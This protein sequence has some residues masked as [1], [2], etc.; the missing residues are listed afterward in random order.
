LKTSK[1]ETAV[2]Y[3]EVKRP[4]IGC[5]TPESVCAGFVLF[6]CILFN[7]NSLHAQL[8]EIPSGDSFRVEFQPGESL[9]PENSP[10]LPDSSGSF[11]MDAGSVY[12]PVSEGRTTEGSPDLSAAVPTTVYAP[13]DNLSFS[14]PSIGGSGASAG[15]SSGDPEVRFFPEESPFQFNLTG[16]GDPGENVLPSPTGFLPEMDFQPEIS[17]EAGT[18]SDP[19][20]WSGVSRDQPGMIK[21]AQ[22]YQTAEME[23]QAIFVPDSPVSDQPVVITGTY[24]WKGMETEDGQVYILGGDCQVNQGIDVVGGPRAVVWVR[25]PVKE[26]G[27]PGQAIVYLE[28]EN[29]RSPLRIE[30]NSP[31]AE[32]RV[33]DTAWLGTFKTMA[34]IDIH[35][36]SP[37]DQ[38]LDPESLYYRAGQFRERSINREDVRQI[39]LTGSLTDSVTGQLAGLRDQLTDKNA[40]RQIRFFPRYD[41]SS[42]INVTTDPSNPDKKIGIINGGVNIILS[43]EI[44]KQTGEVTNEIVDISTD[45]AVIW[46]TGLEYLNNDRENV[47]NSNF[48]LEIFLEGN[49]VFRQADRVI[50]AK[51]M[52]YDAKNQ[53]GLIQN[54]EVVFPIPNTPGGYFRLQ[55]DQIAQRG[56]SSISATNTWVSTSMMGEPTYRLQSNSLRAESVEKPLY[57]SVTGQPLVNPE[58]GQPLSQVNQYLVAENNFVT[59]GCLPVFYWP[60]MAMD[61]KDQTLYLRDI[62]VGSDSIYGVQVKTRWNPYQLLN[63]GEKCR[64]K[65]T[66]WDL[67]IDYLSDR[68]LGHGTTFVYNRDTVFGFNTPAIGLVSYYGISDKGTDNLGLGRRN[69][70]FPH[71]YRYRLL[72]KHRQR[73]DNLGCFGSGWTLTGQV[74]TSRDRN[75]L[76]QYF[77]NE[78]YSASNPETSVE[79]KK[80]VNNWSLGLSAAVRTDSFYTQSNWLPRLDHYWM[81]QPIGFLNNKVVYYE[82]TKLGFAQ[83][84]TTDIPYSTEDKDLWRYLNWELDPASVSNSPYSSDVQPLSA[85]S[86]DFSTRHELDIPVQAG[87]FKIKPYGLGEFA[88]WGQGA[89]KKNVTRLY[90]RGGVRLDL[91]LWMVNS[92]VNSSTWYLNGLAHKTNF[93]VDGSYSA[94]NRSFDELILYEPLDDWQI[95]DFRRRY[96]VTTFG[97]TGV[98]GFSDSIPI[99]FDERY[100]ALR[101]G[102]LGGSVSSPGTEIAD[103]LTLVRFEWQNRWQTKRGPIGQRHTVDWIT[104]NTGFNLYPKKKE[105]FDEYLGLIDYD[106]RW[107]VG[108]RFSVLSSGMYDVFGSGQRITRMGVMTKKPGLSS[109]YF[110]VDRLAGPIDSTYL[111]LAINYRMSE[112]WASGFSTSYDLA[113]RKNV[114]QDLSVSRIGESF[115]VTL[116]AHI[117]TSKDN[118]GIKFSLEPIFYN[119]IREDGLL[120][121]GEM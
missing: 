104:F 60:W 90:G 19:G 113:E 32:A 52:Y 56:P 111:N 63:I 1:I 73:F 49:I 118:W 99:R 46:F 116:G 40:K 108:D 14:P 10:L 36:A 105:N 82:H 38:Q 70:T 59:V 21:V 71:S 12:A 44:K 24:G 121:L 119:R 43:Q 30:L 57:D 4:L 33:N 11:P 107:H 103:D 87:P 110:G 27:T 9:S 37:G 18:L 91:P 6:F 35:I 3:Q 31:Y 93:V 13:T 20:M 114:G 61:A 80:T 89:D 109:V 53:I 66:E 22:N 26:S 72:A 15:H 83:F 5:F 23:N 76:A 84:K 95:E 7:L 79:F 29:S 68:G 65:G 117:N 94:T 51:K 67:D 101:H 17:F 39:P 16:T 112:K 2:C 102:Q 97:G 28:K 69:V 86:L 106:A 98:A 81:G 55:A 45:N 120:G 8:A 47:Q 74:G 41:V 42:P 50:Y 77:E 78:W 75:Y 58:T 96:S 115:I 92:S 64:P 100:Y 88:Y 25:N 48:D 34:G 85:D 54:T 62:Q